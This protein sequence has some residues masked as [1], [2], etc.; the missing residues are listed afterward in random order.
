MK[1]SV[2]SWEMENWELKSL[3]NEGC[4]ENVRRFSKDGEEGDGVEKSDDM[5]F[6]GGGV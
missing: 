2:V 5:H 1:A 4:I 3:L 6:K